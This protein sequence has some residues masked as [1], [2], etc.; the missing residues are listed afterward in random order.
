MSGFSGSTA[1]RRWL[2]QLVCEHSFHKLGFA[3]LYDE[4]GLCRLV[5]RCSTCGKERKSRRY[6]LVCCEMQTC[7]WPE[8]EAFLRAVRTPELPEDAC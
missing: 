5:Y 4:P 7:R 3:L 1:M 8:E 2:K 6:H